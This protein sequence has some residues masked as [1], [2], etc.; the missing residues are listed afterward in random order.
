MWCKAHSRFFESLPEVMRLV[1]L[2]SD[3]LPACLPGDLEVLDD[4]PNLRRWD[5]LQQLVAYLLKEPT[6]IRIWADAQL[7][8]TLSAKSFQTAHTPVGQSI[9]HKSRCH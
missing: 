1:S 6:A 9:A 8:E 3:L 7:P 2:L 4:I 5:P